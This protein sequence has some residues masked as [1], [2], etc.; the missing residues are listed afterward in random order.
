MMGLAGSET[1]SALMV[2]SLIQKKSNPQRTTHRVSGVINS[3]K[4]TRMPPPRF[5]TPMIQSFRQGHNTVIG[6]V[7]PT[8][9]QDDARTFGFETVILER[10]HVPQWPPSGVPRLSS[11]WEY[12]GQRASANG[13]CPN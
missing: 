11:G 6:S 1:V 8:A 5:R 2:A 4:N 7:L 12:R 9:P 3:L 13:R 10:P